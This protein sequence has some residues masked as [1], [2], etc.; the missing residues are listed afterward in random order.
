MGSS[1]LVGLWS[2]LSSAAHTCPGQLGPTSR[3]MSHEA[4]YVQWVTGIWRGVG[5][6]S[7]EGLGLQ[8]RSSVIGRCGAKGWASSSQRRSGEETRL[9]LS[10]LLVWEQRSLQSQEPACPQWDISLL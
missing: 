5:S 2:P 9:P 4:E 7:Q 8:V 10:Y 6:S 1:Y 3:R